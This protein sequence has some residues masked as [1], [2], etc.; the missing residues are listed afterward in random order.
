M[1]LKS[2]MW[3]IDPKVCIRQLKNFNPN[4]PNDSFN[5][6]NN[7]PS[8]PL[9]LPRQIQPTKVADIEYGLSQCRP[10]IRKS[11]QWS[12][13]A[14][15][16]EWDSFVDNSNEVVLNAIIDGTELEMHRESRMSDGRGYHHG[17]SSSAYLRRLYHGDRD[18][19]RGPRCPPGTEIQWIG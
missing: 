5:S 15:A 16:E 3:P 9:P 7:E 19:L 13:P 18:D 1:H 14:R 4:D 2:R 12:D 6:L 10:K 8:L 11:M 17:H